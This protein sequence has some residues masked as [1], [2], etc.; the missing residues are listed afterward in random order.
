MSAAGLRNL[1]IRADGFFT[2][3][4]ELSALDLLSPLG[5][6]VV[7]ASHTGRKTSV[8]LPILTR[9]ADSLWIEARGR[10]SS[11]QG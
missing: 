9:I 6:L 3:N 7:L 2:Q 10:T 8:V 4:P 5:K 1:K 11:S